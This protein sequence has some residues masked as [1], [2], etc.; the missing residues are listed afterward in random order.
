MSLFGKRR[1]ETP[2]PEKKACPDNRHKWIPTGTHF[3]AD[4]GYGGGRTV[5]HYACERCGEQTRSLFPQ[6]QDACHI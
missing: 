1:K 2:G 6:P 4:M 3:D 5:Y